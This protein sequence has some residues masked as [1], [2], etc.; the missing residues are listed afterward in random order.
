MAN[1]TR[2]DVSEHHLSELLRTFG[3]SAAAQDLWLRSKLVIDDF[4]KLLRDEVVAGRI[5]ETDDKT[6][7]EI[8]HA[9]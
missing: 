7:L 4:Y 5:A 1:K 6:R 9:S 2:G 3:G 8:G